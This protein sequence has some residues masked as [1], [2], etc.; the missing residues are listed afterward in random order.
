MFGLKKRKAKE[1]QIQVVPTV[2]DAQTDPV[3]TN[4]RGQS[5]TSNACGGTNQ[6]LPPQTAFREVPETPAP[7]EPKPVRCNRDKRLR[8]RLTQK[9]M[10]MVKRRAKEAGTDCSKYVRRELSAAELIHTPQPDCESLRTM[11]NRPGRRLDDILARAYKTGFI[12]VPEL[13]KT[14]SELRECYR[15]IAAFYGGDDD[16]EKTAM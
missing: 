4:V 1:K 16:N 15:E 14:L 7:A 8:I 10:D 2:T 9:E 11:L 13:E 12:D 3:E 5:L 6:D